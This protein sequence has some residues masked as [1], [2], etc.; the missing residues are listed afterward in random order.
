MDATANKGLNMGTVVIDAAQL[1][2]KWNGSPGELEAFGE[3]LSSLV[4]RPVV[5]AKSHN[6]GD[7]TNVSDADWYRAVD[8]HAERFPA[9]WS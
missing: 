4:G 6:G 9:A 2:D 3:I 8:A 7:A 1:G 5:V